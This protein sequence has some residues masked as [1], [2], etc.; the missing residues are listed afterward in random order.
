MRRKSTCIQRQ[1][2]MNG[3]VGTEWV[4][5]IHYSYSGTIL[6][7][8]SRGREN[9]EE[10][11]WEEELMKRWDGRLREVREKSVGIWGRLWRWRY[12]QSANRK[13]RLCEFVMWWRH[14][15]KC[16]CFW[17]GKELLAGFRSVEH[18]K[19]HLGEELTKG[20]WVVKVMGNSCACLSTKSI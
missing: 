16:I 9:K 18:E 7:G 14:F 5:C 11:V 20:I 10:D 13:I 3:W 12:F 2:L 17:E 19:K 8:G 4:N 15:I 6:L 1:R